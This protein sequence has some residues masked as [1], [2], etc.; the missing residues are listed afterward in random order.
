MFEK[1]PVQFTP[2]PWRVVDPPQKVLVAAHL[3]IATKP[4]YFRQDQLAMRVKLGGLRLADNVP[5]WLHAWVLLASLHFVN[6]V[7]RERVLLSASDRIRRLRG[8]AR[9]RCRDGSVGA[10]PVELVRSGKRSSAA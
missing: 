1:W 5:G 6:A 10:V 4:K 9:P 8:A 7:L 2:E 3:A